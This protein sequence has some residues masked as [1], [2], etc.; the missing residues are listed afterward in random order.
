L[1]VGANGSEAMPIV[2]V[3]FGSV[4]ALMIRKTPGSPHS[5]SNDSE[6]ETL[7]IIKRQTDW[8]WFLLDNPIELPFHTATIVVSFRNDDGENIKASTLT[9]GPWIPG[10]AMPPGSEVRGAVRTVFVSPSFLFYVGEGYDIPKILVVRSMIVHGRV[11]L[12]NEQLSRVKTV[13]VGVV[14]AH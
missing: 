11:A 13:D 4:Q 6:G 1:G 14:Q 8:K 5:A 9:L 2:D 7:I 10:I 3:D 12:E